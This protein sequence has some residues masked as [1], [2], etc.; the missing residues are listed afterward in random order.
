[1]HQYVERFRH[2]GLHTVV[3]VDDVFVHLRSTSHVVG[4]D[5]EHFLQC[6]GSTVCFQGPHFH[7][8]ETLATKLSLTT[9]RLLS[10]QTVGASG[11]CVHFVV[12]Q[13]VQL[14]H[15]HIADG[16]R[17]LEGV[18]STAVKQYHLAG[19]RQIRQT[20]QSLNFSLLSTVKH[21]RRHRNAST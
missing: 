7:L 6:I 1:L 5:S 14:Q 12:D 18:A 17:A 2:A 11:A 4:F 10:N 16:N 8:P 3:A 15:V 21:R 13:V 19:F 20:Q 9:Q